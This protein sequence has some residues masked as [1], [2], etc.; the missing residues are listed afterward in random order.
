MK[1]YWAFKVLEKSAIKTSQ[2]SFYF[3]AA[4]ADINRF[5]FLPPALQ[6][7]LLAL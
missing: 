2:L 6:F 1:F 3:I 7:I 4:N 5:P